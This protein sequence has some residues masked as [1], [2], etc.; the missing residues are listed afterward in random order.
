MLKASTLHLVVLLAKLAEANNYIEQ[1]QQVIDTLQHNCSI[2]RTEAT[3]DF[4]IAIT[5]GYIS[6]RLGVRKF[7]ASHERI[8]QALADQIKIAICDV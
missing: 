8:V 1:G 7:L 5:W 4:N 2:V 6:D 3:I